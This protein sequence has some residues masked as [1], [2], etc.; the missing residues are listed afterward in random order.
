MPR[1]HIEFIHAQDLDWATSTWPEPL[2]DVTCKMLSRDD[3]TGAC[4]VIL[5]Y[6]A[7]WSASGEL[8]LAADHEFMVLEGSVNISGQA[9]PFDSYAHLP[10][11]F[12]HRDWKSDDGA[13]VLTF[14]SETPLPRPGLGNTTRDPIPYI[15]LHDMPWTSADVDPDL[16]FL[17]I[18]HKV[19]RVD[20]DSG[21]TTLLLNCGAQSHPADWKEAAL[22][23]PCVEEMFLLSGDII[24]ER[25]IMHAGSYFWRPPNIWH[26]PFGSRYGN[27]CLIRFMEGHHVNNWGDEKLPFSLT[28][29]YAPD[30]PDHLSHLTNKPFNA[31]TPY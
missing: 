25:G 2:N 5:K 15:F 27:V 23:H 11:G 31:P 6:P 4:S 26:G 18:A 7:G 16:D 19:L 8:H 9:Y 20:E 24:A 10:A 22:A 3:E 21:E 14:F 17:R 1:P 29:T 28:P 30:L 12:T 13:V